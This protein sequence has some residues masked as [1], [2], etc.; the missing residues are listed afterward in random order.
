MLVSTGAEPV[1]VQCAFIDT[2]EIE[3]LTEFIGSQQGYPD[4]MHLPEYID[5]SEIAMLEVDLKKRDTMFDE[6]ARLVVQHQQGSTS[7]IQRKLS[8]GYNRAG[9]IIDQLEAAGIVGPFEGSKARD[10]M[11]TDL[12]ALEQILKR[13]E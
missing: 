13:L 8:I 5:D 9:R 3:E 11:V 4:A 7:L 1:R 2:P 6:A 10:V 12:I